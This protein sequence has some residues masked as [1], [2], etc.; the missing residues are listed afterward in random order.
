MGF[1]SSCP[2]K[3]LVGWSV[4][5]GSPGGSLPV[6]LSPSFFNSPWVVQSRRSVGE[7]RRRHGKPRT[8]S[9]L[10]YFR[11]VDNNLELKPCPFVTFSCPVERVNI[12][13]YLA[14]RKPQS[15]AVVNLLTTAA[16]AREQNMATK[17]VA[18]Q[19]NL[20]LHSLSGSLLLCKL[21][22]KANRWMGHFVIRFPN[23]ASLWVNVTLSFQLLLWKW[24]FYCLVFI[25][26]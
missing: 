21:S 19:Q 26:Q 15:H 22:W 2:G 8:W 10:W 7:P 12:G 16:A 1:W 11:V 13:L 14:W 18:N 24:E 5:G 6:V 9:K 23:S 17:L 25:S 20:R 3:I 4:F